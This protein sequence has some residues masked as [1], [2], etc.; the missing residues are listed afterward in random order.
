MDRGL[1]RLTYSHNANYDEIH[2]L[3]HTGKTVNSTNSTVNTEP[4]LH[5]Y[6]SVTAGSTRTARSTGGSAASMAAS[7]KTTTGVA[8]AD[9]SW[10]C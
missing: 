10:L 2:H 5:S 9:A 4:W 8:T 1:R 6:R 7:S 3:L